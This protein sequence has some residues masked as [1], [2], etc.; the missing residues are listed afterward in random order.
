MKIIVIMLEE[1]DNACHVCG[2]TYNVTQCNHCGRYECL[3]CHRKY[4]YVDGFIYCYM[5][6]SRLDQFWIAADFKGKPADYIEKLRN[7]D[8]VKAL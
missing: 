3:D 4:E 5:C 7:E 1:S 8:G 6:Q 2:G